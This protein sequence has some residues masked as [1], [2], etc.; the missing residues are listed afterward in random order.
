M[1]RRELTNTNA[2]II[3]CDE[4]NG[5]MLKSKRDITLKYGSKTLT[6]RG[7][8]VYVCENCDNEVI[9]DKEFEMI[10]NLFK[11]INKSKIDILNLDETAD[12]LRVSNQTIYNM[13]SSNRIKAYKV[14][15]EWRFMRSDIE[16]YLEG[17]STE[18]IWGAAAKGGKLSSSDLELI[19]REV[20]RRK[21][22]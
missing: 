22:E 17:V 3:I 6:V 20:S 2:D 21:H 7:V 5:K 8:D 19:K 11:S 15:R 16:A 12:L 14:G 13:I 9:R 18:Q 1:M 10:E 4:C